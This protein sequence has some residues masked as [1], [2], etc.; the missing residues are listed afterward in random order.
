MAGGEY[1]G[2]PVYV[3]SICDTRGRPVAAIGVIDT[4]GVL[5]PQ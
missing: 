2:I 5:S 1:R 3:S 4:A